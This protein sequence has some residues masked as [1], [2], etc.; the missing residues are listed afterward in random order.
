MMIQ[1]DLTLRPNCRR[2][3]EGYR[4]MID[5]LAQVGPKQSTRLLPD[6]KTNATMASGTIAVYIPRR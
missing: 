3:P 4:R 5:L 6:I 2:R 1:N